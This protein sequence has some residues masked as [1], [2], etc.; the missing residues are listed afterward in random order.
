[1]KAA[2]LKW[3]E[4]WINY[5]SATG[6]LFRDTET[7]TPKT[8]PPFIL[9]CISPTI[10]W[11]LSTSRNQTACDVPSAAFSQINWSEKSLLNVDVWVSDLLFHHPPFNFCCRK[12][13]KKSWGLS[14][15]LHSSKCVR[16][17]SRISLNWSKRIFWTNNIFKNVLKA[18]FVRRISAA[19]PFY[20]V[21]D[22]I[23][24]CI[25]PCTNT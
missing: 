8:R 2:L 3:V 4:T 9:I 14:E 1:M 22:T 18:V 15:T 12:K 25:V 24:V 17:K 19:F 21:N 16:I 23:S 6:G 10:S 5:Y 7:L 11:N 13:K 20:I